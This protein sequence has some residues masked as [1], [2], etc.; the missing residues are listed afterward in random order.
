MTWETLGEGYINQMA[1]RKKKTSEN[2]HVS[3]LERQDSRGKSDKRQVKEILRDCGLS[4]EDIF[5]RIAEKNVTHEGRIE[6][7]P[8]VEKVFVQG[9]R[10][11]NS[12]NIPY[13]VGAAF[14]RHAYTG[15]WRET[16]D[17][18]IF[19]L[20]KD[21]Q[22]AFEALENEGFSTSVMYEHWLAKAYFG[23]IFIDLIFGTG[24][25]QVQVDEAWIERGRP[26][27]VL[28]VATRLAAIEEMITTSMFVAERNRFDG[29][30]V[31]HLINSARGNLDWDRILQLVGEENREILLWNLILFDIVYPGHYD[32]LPKDLIVRLFQEMRTRWKNNKIPPKA[33]RGM[34]LD[35]FSF[36]VD[37]E[38][39]GYEDRRKIAPIVDQEGAEL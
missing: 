19:L 2:G 23:D 25:G 39:W 30:E 27:V 16:K 20:P 28:G 18:D 33:F 5:D 11:L 3:P 29:A 12:A 32:Y 7:E 26:G 35:P 34:I 10:A 38:N 22:A 36:E 21:L 14:A 31:V 15:I 24:H 37:L 8:E 17:I 6:L 13:V 9:L 4:E 1:A